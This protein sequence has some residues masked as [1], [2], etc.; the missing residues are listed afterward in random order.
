MADLRQLLRERPVFAGDL[1]AF[2]P[3]DTPVEPLG[4]FTPGRRTAGHRTKELLWP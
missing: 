2:D 1:P 4:L 3:E